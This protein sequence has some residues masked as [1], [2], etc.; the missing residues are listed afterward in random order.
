MRILHVASWFQ[1]QLGYSEYHLPVAQQR[2]GHTVA[3]VTSDRYFPFPNYA[4]TVRPIL[5]QRVVGPSVR[6]ELGVL[7]YRLPVLFEYR[8]HLWLRGLKRVIS[9]FKPDV[10]QTH[11]AFS[12]PV[13]Q[14]AIAKRQIP[15]KL[16]IKSSMEK[17][18]FYPQAGLRRVYYRLFSTIAAPFLRRQ[19]DVFSAVGAGAR[20]IV[21][22]IFRLTPLSV[23]I[24][25]LGADSEKFRRNETARKLI[26][27][28]LGIG[29]D[30]VLA[31]Y[32]GKLI[33]N[34]DIHVLTEAIARADVS[35]KLAVL[36]VGN[37]SSEY[38][39]RLKESAA[40]ATCPVFFH[41]A[42]PNDELPS[43]FS[44]ADIGVWPAESSNAAIEAALTGLPLVVSRT[45]AT[46][47]YISA[48]N[49][50]A[51][52]R[53]D[54]QGLLDCLSAIAAD[55]DLRK[56]MGERGRLY[57]EKNLSW[58][59]I[60]RRSIRMYESNSPVETDGEMSPPDVVGA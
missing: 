21:A 55:A 17:E 7:A 45:E 32:A 42:V 40:F 57:C 53:G 36:V 13:I 56:R 43:Y 52:E 25:P 47:H 33:S 24:L 28:R 16:I 49:G 54:A 1:P 59:A 9:E 34:K 50:L 10:V 5:G 58:A 6:E 29:E 38:T 51:F 39:S 37:G 60:A 3:V 4:S 20:D 8:H 35:S 30:V 44:A 11:Q 48:S 46:Q 19:I 2:L 27:S 14:A 23:E 15:F 31:V 22:E 26:R 18:V 41:P 12:L